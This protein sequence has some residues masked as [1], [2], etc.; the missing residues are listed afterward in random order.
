MSSV[1]SR[2][3]LTGWPI[4]QARPPDFGRVSDTQD[5]WRHILNNDAVRPDDCAVANSDAWHHKS[6]S[7]YPCFGLYVDSFGYD[8]EARLGVVMGGCRKIAMLRNADIIA[9]ANLSHRME[10]CI[11][12]NPATIADL[13]F[14][15][16]GY[17][18]RRPDNH[19]FTN[20]C[21]ESGKQ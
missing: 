4:V 1:R 8:V 15:W 20:F 17:L 16:I 14:P 6:S 11:I 2:L 5:H 3:R 21:S 10:S 9:N 7:R 13:Q 18:G 12:A 19:C